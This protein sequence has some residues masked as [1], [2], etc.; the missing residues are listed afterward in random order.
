MESSHDAGH[1]TYFTM[2]GKALHNVK[3]ET[4]FCNL[5]CSSLEVD[6]CVT[7]FKA[8]HEMRCTKKNQEMKNGLK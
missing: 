2:L 6:R 4:T 3:L 8:L 5:S 1:G 7:K